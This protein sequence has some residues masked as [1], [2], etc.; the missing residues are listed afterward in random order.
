L[1]VGVRPSSF[2]FTLLQGETK[3]QNQQ[4]LPYRTPLLWRQKLMALLGRLNRGLAFGVIMFGALLA[5]ELF[6]YTTTDFALQDFLGDIRFLGL[7]WAMIL[8][9]AFCGMDFAGIA[10]LFTPAGEKGARVEVW[11]LLGAWF[12]A[13]TMNAMLTWWGVSLALLQHQALGNEIL[14]REQLIRIVPV[15]VAVLVWLIRILMI[16]TFSMAGERLFARAEEA[17]RPAA[18]AQ[19]QT[20]PLAR[21]VSET[22]P[23]PVRML[24][25]AEEDDFGPSNRER[26]PR[27]TQYRDEQPRQERPRPVAPPPPE[28]RRMPVE[29]PSVQPVTPPMP[30]V[31]P[32][33]KPSV[34]TAHAL[35]ANGANGT[36]GTGARPVAARPS[37]MNGHQDLD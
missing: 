16:G 25:V 19:A 36:N 31:R 12:L 27:E 7:R 37:P 13:A 32:A 11:Y 24:G 6:N 17:L 2:N 14:S 5:F 20:R 3:M 26:S 22:A 21:P 33:P 1:N 4:N 9:I 35:S 28:V 29:R 30:A 18:Q 15:F 8:S 34:A 23:R 10:R